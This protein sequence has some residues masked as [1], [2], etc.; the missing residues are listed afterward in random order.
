MNEPSTSGATLRVA[1]LICSDR[2][3]SGARGDETAER[4]RPLLQAAGHALATVRVVAD[5]QDAIEGTLRELA[6]GHAVV[7]TSGGTGLAARDVTV[8]ATRAVLDREIPGLGEAMRAKSLL[9]TPTAMLSRATAG[10]FGSTLIV[11][12]PGSPKG[13]AECLAVVLPVVP[14]A[15]R[16]LAGSVKDCQKEIGR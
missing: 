3:A 8:E 7:L 13:A 11:N 14:H 1:L 2:A 4:I 12:L 9:A 5:E 10:T 16:L 6:S 15:A